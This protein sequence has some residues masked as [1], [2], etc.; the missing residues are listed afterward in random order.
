MS[1]VILDNLVGL[2]LRER[3]GCVVEIGVSSLKHNSTK[4]LLDHAKTA[5][6]N[7]YTC[8]K[9]EKKN[10]Q[11]VYEKHRHFLG[12]SFDF[13]ETFND[14]PAVVL[15]DGCPEYDVAIREVKFFLEKLM[16]GGVIFLHNTYPSG[17]KF[18]DR[19]AC[20]D[21]YRVRQEMEK[22]KDVDCFTW[23]YASVE[24]NAGLTMI[25]KKPE[26][27]PYYQE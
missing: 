20:A 5:G 26:G 3:K 4:V 9:N 12:K 15:L 22:E 8:D 23:P 18:L 27:R 6:V 16:N 13:M 25:L 11:P 2:I 7:F 10:L 1:W 24:C 14:V 19:G 21:C 17:E